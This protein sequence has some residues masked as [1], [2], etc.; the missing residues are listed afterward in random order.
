MFLPRKPSEAEIERFV[1]SQKNLPFSYERVGAT[2]GDAPKG[3]VVD[4]Y[5]VGLGEGEEAYGRAKDALRSWRQFG[6][7]WVGV[8]PDDAPVEVG[9]TVGVLASHAG[10]WSLNPARIV[11]LV[12]ESGDVERFGFAYG[13]L[14]GHAERGEERFVVEHDR[15]SGAVSYSVFAFSRPNHPLAWI[16]YPF[17]RLLQRRFARDSTEAMKKIVSACAADRP[18]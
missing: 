15:R 16:G 2:R 3:Y 18:G 8:R 13:T 7:G 6:L 4:R 11:Y 14:P 9:A 1:S 10:F 17:A 5:R 12:Q